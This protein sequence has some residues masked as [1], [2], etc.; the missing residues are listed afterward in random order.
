MENNQRLK[1]IK[2]AIDH[3]DANDF[4]KSGKPE[5]DALNAALKD[6]SPD[7]EAVTGKERDEAWETLEAQREEDGHKAER[8]A[9][10]E[11]S[12]ETQDAIADPVETPL[13]AT[14]GHKAE[15]IAADE[16]PVEARSDD[17]EPL[18]DSDGDMVRIRLL[19]ARANPLPVY[20]N[21][22]SSM[23]L[24]VGEEHDVP[25]E[26]LDAIKASDATYE[27]VE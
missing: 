12:V 4:T 17:N 22:R 23:R 24:A 14:P 7:A 1:A 10:D 8:E 27:E 21:G 15:R 16:K 26:V 5:V 25:R 13:D 20:I 11:Q 6:T 2:A 9:D 3:L 18:E 19:T